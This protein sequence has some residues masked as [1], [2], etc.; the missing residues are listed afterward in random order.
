MTTLQEQIIQTLGAKP[1]IDAA[2]EIQER[3]NF[4]KQFTLN[5][6]TKGFVLGISGG[7]DSALAG[8]LAQIAAEQ[9]R[10]ETGDDS[11]QFLALLLPYGIQKDAADALTIAKD[12]IKADRVVNFNIKDTVDAFQDTFNAAGDVE[13]LTDY[14][15][16]NIKARVRM[17]TQY[18]YAGQR[19]LLVVGTD[20][21]SEAVSGFFTKFGDGGADILP[22]AGLNKHQGKE[23]LRL[24]DAPEFVI[25]KAPTADLLDVVQ[26]QPDETEL[27]I[28]YE[29][30][31]N[32]LEG[33]TVAA[34]AAE[35]IETRYLKTEHKRQ[36]PVTITDTWWK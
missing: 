22:L 30:L 18:A 4:L 6:G 29:V 17:T 14:H 16:G 35:K 11:Y 31:D 10:A 13:T 32:Y 3:V 36:L 9:L 5:A 33:E 15:K 25:T 28:T 1:S 20:H 8:K 2:Q 24:L 27:G 7:Q 12:F 19:G 26:Q 34:D 21:N 23:L